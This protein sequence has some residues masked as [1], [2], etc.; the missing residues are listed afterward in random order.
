[1]SLSK[2]GRMTLEELKEKC[3]SYPSEERKRKGPVAVAECVEEI[4]C[5]PCESSCRLGAIDI[6]EEITNCPK[7]NPEKCVG[8]GVCVAHCSG[9]AIFVMDKSYSDITGT[10]AFPYEYQKVPAVGE[11]VKATDRAGKVVCD[12]LVKKVVMPKS[13]DRTYVVTIEVPIDMVEIVRGI[14]IFEEEGV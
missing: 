14:Q 4:P 2:N 1:M 8:C 5:N 10:V 3:V 13:Y 9:M 6:G 7:I 11:S 12:G